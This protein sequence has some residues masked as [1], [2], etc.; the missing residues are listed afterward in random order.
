M[1]LGSEYSLNKCW[2]IRERL[3]VWFKRV[4]GDE[5]EKGVDLGEI[6]KVR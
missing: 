4:I 1:Y 5:I 3:E 2:K 6:W